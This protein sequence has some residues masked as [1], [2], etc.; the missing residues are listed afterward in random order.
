MLTIIMSAIAIMFMVLTPLSYH[1][2][3]TSVPAGIFGFIGYICMVVAVG[4][5]MWDE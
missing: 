5:F 2:V 3:T 1:D 4:N